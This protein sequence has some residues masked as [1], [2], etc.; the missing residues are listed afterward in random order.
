[1]KMSHL[2]ST[3]TSTSALLTVTKACVLEIKAVQHLILVGYTDIAKH[4]CE[5]CPQTAHLGR[6]CARLYPCHLSEWVTQRQILNDNR[7]VLPDFL[8]VP[9]LGQLLSKS[10]FEF[11]Y[12][13][14][15][16]KR[17]KD[18]LVYVLCIADERIQKDIIDLLGI[19]TTDLKSLDLVQKSY[20]H[21]W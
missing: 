13:Q 14:K 9:G 11:Q 10:V 3:W 16:D 2:V 7:P 12:E 15:I 19:E 17:S 20:S 18:K 1:M 8:L 6:L 5:C 4:L 21:H